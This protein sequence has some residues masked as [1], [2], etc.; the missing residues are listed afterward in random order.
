MPRIVQV[1]DVGELLRS[2]GTY[3]ATVMAGLAI[4]GLLLLPLL[5]LLLVRKNPIRFFLDMSA[6]IMT[7]FG[8]S[9][10]SATIPVTIKSLEDLSGLDSRVVRFCI[11]VGATLNMNGTALYEAVAALFISQVRCW[12]LSPVQIV[13]VSITATAAS[14]GAAGIPQAGLVTMVIVLQAVGLPVEDVALIFVVDWFL[15]R[16]RTVI[17]VLGD[18]F[19][20]AIVNHLS[21][22]DL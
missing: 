16:F 22:S 8:T 2:V 7:S 19:V 14:V 18:C 3:A 11:P 21:R 20:A 12:S 1:D 13:L 10:S 17:N 5:Y 9:S 4:H 15:D 6:V